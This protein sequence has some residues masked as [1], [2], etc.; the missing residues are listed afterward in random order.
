MCLSP[1]AR[2]GRGTLIGSPHKDQG[3]GVVQKSIVCHYQKRACRLGQ[4]KQWPSTKLVNIVMCHLELVEE[5]VKRV[6]VT[7]P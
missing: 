6:V 1:L 5:V 2:G 3:I 7:S 4:H